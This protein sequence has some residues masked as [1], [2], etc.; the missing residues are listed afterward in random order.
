MTPRL[1]AYAFLVATMAVNGVVAWLSPLQGNDWNHV[2]WAR[3]HA[4]DSTF[5]FVTTWLAQHATFHDATGYL[6]ASSTLAHALMTPLVACALLW[7]MFTIA[8]RRRPNLDDWQDVVVLVTLSA[9]LWFAAPRAGVTW[10]HRP[11]VAQWIYGA[12][13]TLWFLAPYRC[14]WRAPRYAS[15]LLV[16]AGFCAG[17]SGRQLGFVALVLA[18]LAIRK[19][20]ERA[21]WMWAGLVGLVAGV[22]LA[23]LDR[24]QIDFSGFRRGVEATFV[25]IDFPI[26]EGGELI[27]LVLGLVLVKLVLARVRPATADPSA[28]DTSETLRWLWVWFAFAVISMFGPK[29]T[30]AALFPAS[31]TLCIAAYPVVRWLVTT[32]A[33]RVFLAALAIGAHTIVWTISLVTYVRVHAMFTDRM[34]RLTTGSGIVEIAP[35]FPVRS[36]FWFI[37]EDLATLLQRQLVAISVFHLDDIKI[38]PTFRGYERA[39]DVSVKLEVEGISDAQLRSARPPR[40]WAATPSVARKQLDDLVGRMP[41]AGDAG[42]AVRLVAD[43]APSAARGRPVLVGG[44]ERGVS[45]VPKVTRRSFDEVN[46]VPITVRPASFA[47]DYPDAFV[48]DGTTESRIEPQNGVYQVPATNTGNQILVACGATRCILLEAFVPRL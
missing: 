32:P 34:E 3:A 21:R 48:I 11:Y 45:I 47:K 4:D 42:A 23:F 39:A 41:G 38:I 27:S 9:F 44:Y 14:G 7:G 24:P 36:T 29:F 33:L 43:L 30:D 37:G 19:A 28:P 26:R 5:A 16:I 31:I 6:L 22:V 18:I 2:M 12:T 46:N 10:F 13:V 35:Y 8:A 40:Q 17:S 1:A 20:P 15:V 25:A